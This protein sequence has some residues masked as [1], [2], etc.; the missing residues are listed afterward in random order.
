M[1]ANRLGINGLR[2]ARRELYA[3][4]RR[5]LVAEAGLTDPFLFSSTSTSASASISD[6]SSAL[7]GHRH[8]TA[9]PGISNSPAASSCPAASVAWPAGL[10]ASQASSSIAESPSWSA[11]TD[12]SAESS[13][14]TL[15]S[16][17]GSSRLAGSSVA[18]SPFQSA[19]GESDI[20]SDERLGTPT[21]LSVQE[22]LQQRMSML[23]V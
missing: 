16:D 13:F 18:S 19:P 15:L 12:T 3:A 11:L 23:Q 2:M 1:S 4:R 20:D 5:R 14:A 7:M 8:D 10:S 9:A 21:T 6:T 17:A 22:H